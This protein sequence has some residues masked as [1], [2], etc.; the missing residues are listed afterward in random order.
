[1]TRSARVHRAI[2]I[3][4]SAAVLSLAH[5]AVGT[6]SIPTAPHGDTIGGSAGQVVALS[7]TSLLACT[8]G[9]DNSENTADDTALL[10]TGLDTAT[11]TVTAITI[12][13]LSDYSGTPARLSATAVLLL[14]GGPDNDFGGADDEIV[15]VDRLG[16]GNRVTHITVGFLEELDASQPVP[17]SS[18][19]AVVCTLG[20]DGNNRGLDDRIALIEDLGADT[21][22]VTYL[23]APGFTGRGSGRAVALST[24]SF[25]VAS[26]GPDLTEQTTDDQVY[27]FTDVGGAN[28]RTDLAT[29]TLTRYGA[30]TPVVLS[31]SLAVVTG[32]GADGAEMTADDEIHVLTGLDG[33]TPA[34]TTVLLPN[35]QRYGA[36]RAVPVGPDSILVS[37]EGPDSTGGT[38]DDTV[39]LIT[40]LGTTNTITHITV[41][42]L[43]DDAVCRPTPLGPDAFAVGT[44]GPDGEFENADDEIVV[45]TGFRGASP[46]VTRHASSGLDEGQSSIPLSLGPD[47]I[48]FS[49]AG[50]DGDL[51][52]NASGDDRITVL[53]GLASAAPTLEHIDMDGDNNTFWASQQPI[54]LGGGRVAFLCGGVN[55]QITFGGDDVIQVLDTVPSLRNLVVAR[56]KLT[57]QEARPEKGEKCSVKATLT[58]DGFD[59]FGGLTVT[60]SVGNAGQILPVS[61]FTYKKGTWKYSD[62]KNLNGW[63]KKVQFKEKNGSLQ[64]LGKGLATGME[65][66]DA[67]YLAVAFEGS[68]VHLGQVVV[69][70]ASPKGLSYKAP[71]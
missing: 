58:R 48:L 69:G 3:A 5:A 43:Y 22:T 45:V 12:G 59:P 37:T 52:N 18:D 39:A 55:G 31:P 66:T 28:T 67:G 60:V 16:S 7:A 30:G 6:D 47:T 61:A 40:G 35:I 23:P 34:V 27:L 38:A 53:T 25:L 1:M 26:A 4:A 71:K 63:V 19:R 33:A 9:P 10:V 57:F 46:V 49:N 62:P 2:A 15:R 13:N 42:Y 17:L 11:P 24:D 36:G 8:M 70:T 29:P 64:I 14:A 41:G 20:P 56:A 54:F 51:N 50:P 44:S 32:H 21:P 65:T 68:D